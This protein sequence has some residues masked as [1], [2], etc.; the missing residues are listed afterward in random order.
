MGVVVELLRIGERPTPIDATEAMHSLDPPGSCGHSAQQ[1]R[2][3][4]DRHGSQ[5]TRTE[6]AG[7]T[8]A[9]IPTEG[10][11]A[12][13]RQP[14]V[15]MDDTFA[16][17]AAAV[18]GDDRHRGVLR[19]GSHQRRDGRV[20]GLVDATDRVCERPGDVPGRARI[21]EAP[22]VMRHRVGGPVDD[23]ERVPALA[24]EQ[25][26]R[27]HG[28]ARDPVEQALERPL[29]P[30]R[31]GAELLEIAEREAADQAPQL[32]IEAPR[33]DEG[34]VDRGGERALEAAH[35]DTGHRL[36]RIGRGH[37]HDSD[38]PAR[39]RQP[40]PDRR[41]L[42]VAAVHEAHAIRPRDALGEV[43]DA[44]PARVDARHERGPGGE[45]RGGNRGAETAPRPLP[46]ELPE[47][48]EASRLDPRLDE[49]ER[50][51]VEADHQQRR[52]HPRLS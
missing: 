23:H 43:Q 19:R 24:G 31:T 49:V 48:R 18:I 10:E 33:V 20:Q 30:P 11:Q 25:R 7:D 4:G 51:P 40:R 17:T 13:F 3:Q 32:G 50:R 39:S 36:G 2:L 42:P 26:A 1:P 22:E 29:M 37:G 6:E 35:H 41:R 16:R 14:A 38:P 21:M 34:P 8:L 5:C 27:E 44:M 15:Q 46:H 45:G 9:G 28:A 52:R 47:D 12:A